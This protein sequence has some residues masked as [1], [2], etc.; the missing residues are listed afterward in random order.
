[1]VCNEVGSTLCIIH[2]NV[3]EVTEKR[4]TLLIRSN[5]TVDKLISDIRTQLGLQEPFELILQPKPSLNSVN[6]LLH[7]FYYFTL[8]LL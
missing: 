3:P 5:Y 7:Q 6:R 8:D 4:I 1:M 2:C